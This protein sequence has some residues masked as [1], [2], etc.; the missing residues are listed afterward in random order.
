ME[1]DEPRWRAWLGVSVVC[2]SVMTCYTRVQEKH[3]E[4]D[5]WNLGRL[6]VRVRRTLGP[7]TIR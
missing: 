7:R 6:K 2:I 1:H 5:P 4:A 3:C